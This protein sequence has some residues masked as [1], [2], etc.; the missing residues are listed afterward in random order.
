MVD[1]VRVMNDVMQV[2]DRNRCDRELAAVAAQP[3]PRPRVALHVLIGGGHRA[4]RFDKFGRDGHRVLGAV[5]ILD[6]RRVLVPIGEARLV[7]VEHEPD[8]GVEDA[9]HIADVLQPYSS[10]DHTVG[11]GRTATSAALSLRGHC[12][13]SA[14]MRSATSVWLTA[15]PSKPHSR[16]GCEMTHVQSLVSG[17]IMASV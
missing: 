12:S 9:V 7:L 4:R 17:S 2:I 8:A 15:D 10:L 16:H 1:I 5:V 6:G 14:L 3:A 11:L 13:A